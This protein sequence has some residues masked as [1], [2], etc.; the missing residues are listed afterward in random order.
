MSFQLG[1]RLMPGDYHYL[2][3]DSVVVTT[4]WGTISLHDILDTIMSRLS[5]LSEHHPKASVIDLSNAR[6]VEHPPKFEH[7]E[8][9]RLRPALAPP[10]VRT[11]FVA[12]SDFFFGFARMYAVMH[13]VYGAA[14]VDVVRSW[15]EAGE[16]VGMDLSAAERWSRERIAREESATETTRIPRL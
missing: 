3:Q 9:E 15:A 14:N 11:V 5:E 8:M 16:L 6:W 1:G 10:K 12:S 2:D 13:T 7:R 4:Y